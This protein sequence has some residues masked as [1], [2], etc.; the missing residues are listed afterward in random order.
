MLWE[1]VKVL[2]EKAEMIRREIESIEEQ[3]KDLPSGHLEVKIING[4]RYYY[5]RYWE[6]GKLKSRY[7]GKTAENV[8]QKLIKYEE[9]RKRLTNLKEEER[10]I[11]IVLSKIEKIIIDS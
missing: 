10:K 6:D 1:K 3:I 9:L 11:N 8:K 2:E 4:N 5:L 7:I